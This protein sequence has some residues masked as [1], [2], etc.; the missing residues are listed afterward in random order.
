[1]NAMRKIWRRM[2][3]LLRERIGTDLDEELR[4]HVDETIEASIR[5]GMSPADARSAA[6]RRFGN[7]TLT[8]EDS[9]GVWLL[10]WIEALIQDLHYGLRILRK[11]PG[12]TVVATLTLALRIG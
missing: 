5:A 3:V 6:L 7:V 9:R 10:P 8:K 2:S 4:F 1:M 12:F 11:N